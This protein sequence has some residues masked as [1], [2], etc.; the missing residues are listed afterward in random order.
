MFGVGL[1]GSVV[2]YYLFSSVFILTTLGIGFLVSTVSKNQQQAM[3]SSIFFFILPMVLL[4]GFVFPINNMP[5][6]IQAVTY[7]L[8]LRYFFVIIRGLFLKGVGVIELW[9][10][11]AALLLIAAVLYG[12]AIVRFRKR[13][14]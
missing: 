13:L 11:L 4:G 12:V 14:D 7:A 1:A 5:P 3:M 10:E 6:V 2:L 9:D 8:P